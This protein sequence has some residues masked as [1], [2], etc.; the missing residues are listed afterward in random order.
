MDINPKRET[1]VGIFKERSAA[2]AALEKLVEAHFDIEADANVV[3][4][5]DDVRESVPIMS[6]VPVG[7]GAMIGAA[8]GFFIGA[9]IAG[10]AGIDFGPFSMEAWGPVWAAFETGYVGAAVGVATGAM[11]SFEFAK[12]EAAFHMRTADG[13]VSIGVQAAG[14]RAERARQVLAEAGAEDFV[15]PGPEKVA[16]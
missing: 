10:I 3:V 5:H 15:Q 2:T 1:V 7:R 11:M 16:A 4:V 9:A 6:D 13:V 12:P 8:V 14:S